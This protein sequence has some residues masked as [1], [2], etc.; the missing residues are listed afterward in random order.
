[1]KATTVEYANSFV[2][3]AQSSVAAEASVVARTAGVDSNLTG[4]D[5]T[6]GKTY[7]LGDTAGALSTS[8]GTKKFAVGRNLSTTEM[9]I[10][11]SLDQAT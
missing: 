9:Q 8:Q 10:K 2:G 5:A 7:Y 6:F 3:L 4:L 1:M 11:Y